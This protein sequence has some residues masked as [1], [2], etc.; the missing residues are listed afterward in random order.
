LID[1]QQ[2][3]AIPAPWSETDPYFAA[4]MCYLELQNLNAAK[5]YLDLYDQMVHRYSA[6]ARPGRMTNPYGRY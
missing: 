4:H 2:P 6:Y 3:E 1:D 5:F